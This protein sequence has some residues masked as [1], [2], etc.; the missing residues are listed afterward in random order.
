MAR[1]K[2]KY[3]RGDCVVVKE[4]VLEP[5]HEEMSISGW[6]GRVTMAFEF[7]ERDML[8]IE[9]DSITLQNL[10]DDYLLEGEREGLEWSKIWLYP[11]DVEPTEPRDQIADCR[12]VQTEIASRPV[13][14]YPEASL[15]LIEEVLAGIDGEDPMACVQ[16]WHDYLTLTLKFPFEARA[17]EEPTGGPI[18][19]G[20]LVEVICIRRIESDYGI[21]VQVRHRRHDYLLPLTALEVSDSTVPNFGPVRDYNVWSAAQE[22]EIQSR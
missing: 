13:M 16:A 3:K 6:Q 2:M 7:E 22:A 19:L 9:W 4:G 17:S 15:G 5:E 20:D 8:E 12:R 10:P 11:E 21:L 14:L 1:R 18:R